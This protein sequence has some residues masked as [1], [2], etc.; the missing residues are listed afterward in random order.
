MKKV[1]AQS[2]RWHLCRW[3]L[4]GAVGFGAGWLLKP[5]DP[6][7]DG[8]AGRVPVR[9]GIPAAPVTSATSD[10]KPPPALT[11]QQSIGAKARFLPKDGSKTIYLVDRLRF[12]FADSR[13]GMQELAFSRLIGEMTAADD[14]AILAMLEEVE[15]AG[16]RGVE[17]QRKALHLQWG[18]LDPAAA[19]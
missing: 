5:V 2:N 12:T 17:A 8:A 4:F 13:G 11:D 3:I 15:A 14:P 7:R 16:D 1:F 18:E 19:L 9:Q 6:I 10:V